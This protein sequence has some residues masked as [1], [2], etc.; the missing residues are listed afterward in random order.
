MHGLERLGLREFTVTLGH[1]GILGE[2]LSK[3]G[4]TGRLRTFLLDSVEEVRRRG[5]ERVKTRLQDLDPE[6][7]DPPPPV[8]S[9]AAGE[10]A[11]SAN[12]QGSIMVRSDEDVRSM[13]QRLLVTTG[14]AG[15][16]RRDVTDI[17]ERLRR[18]LD[19]HSHLESVERALGFIAELGTILGTPVS[20]LQAGR[21]FLGRY[22]L[23][24][25]PL[26]ELEAIVDLLAAFGADLGRVRLDLGLSRG[27]Q[28][29]TGTVFEIDHAG[30][31]AESQ[32]CGGGRYDELIRVLGGRQPVPAL[33][34][35][36]GVERIKLALEAEGRTPET[37][38]DAAAFVVAAAPAQSGYAARVAQALRTAGLGVHQEVAQRPLRASPSTRTVRGSATWSW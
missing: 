19:P 7:F 24:D 33:G 12:G 1:V 6:L 38:P 29:Y 37:E 28:Y 2:L 5:V 4:L 23:G 10:V 36:Y 17:A 21:E 18:K 16:G 13:V 15:P 26:R 27:L 32:L 14:T 11:V 35:A 31:G 25:E 22:A 3:L 9:R 20:T 8:P 30:L 34:F